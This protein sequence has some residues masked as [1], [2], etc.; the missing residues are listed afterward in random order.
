ME[1][2]AHCGWAFPGGR[3][4]KGSPGPPRLPSADKDPVTFSRCLGGPGG[5]SAPSPGRAHPRRTAPRLQAAALPPLIHRPPLRRGVR[6]MRGPSRR[7]RPLLGP[8]HPPCRDAGTLLSPFFFPFPACR[9]P[10]PGSC[11]AAARLRGWSR[12]GRRR[13]R[14]RKEEEGGRRAVSSSWRW[15]M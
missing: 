7:S 2:P 10:A 9:P 13:R 8:S 12:G 15:V 11:A 1:Q 4:W 3:G 6:E 14:G 5:P